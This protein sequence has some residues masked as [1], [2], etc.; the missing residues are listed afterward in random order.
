M[1]VS[2]PALC[3]LPATT[4][5]CSSSDCSAFPVATAA[6]ASRGE[7]AAPAILLEKAFGLVERSFDRNGRWGE[8]AIWFAA[9]RSCAFVPVLG[10]SCQVEKASDRF[11]LFLPVCWQQQRSQE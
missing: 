1:R 7:A 5:Y 4:A 11:S 6:A 2:W 9:V 3:R 10:C 8:T